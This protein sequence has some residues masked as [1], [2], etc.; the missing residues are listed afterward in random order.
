MS[1]A[2]TPREYQRTAVEKLIK[3]LSDEGCALLWA[4]MGTGKTTMALLTIKG[5]AKGPVLVVAPAKVATLSWP[6]EMKG[7]FPE[8]SF[9]LLTGKSA[10]ARL[11]VLRKKP[12]VMI[13]NYELLQWLAAQEIE[14]DGIIFDEVDRLKKVGG[15]WRNAVRTLKS[16]WRIGMT[17]TPSTEGYI[18]L[19]GQTDAV[20]PHRWGSFTRWKDRFFYTVRLFGGLY[21]P[22]KYVPVTHAMPILHELV[23]AIT[24]KVDPK[25]ADPGPFELKDHDITFPDDIRKVYARIKSGA[26]TGFGK[27][28][29]LAYSNAFTRCQQAASG[30][31]YD[32][33]KKPTWLHGLKYAELARL[34]Q[35]IPS[36]VLVAFQFEAEA[37]LLAKLFPGCGIIDGRK[38][39]S[40]I[41]AWNAG[42]L[43][44]MCIQ[45][46]SAGYG[47]NLQ[48]GTCRD[49]VFLSLPTSGRKYKQAIARIH[50][51]GNAGTVIV[52]RILIKGTTDTAT[53]ARI[54]EKIQGEQ[55]M[56]QSFRDSEV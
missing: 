23:N 10:N 52:H 48:K 16:R 24:V 47:L 30:F 42:K 49:I 28:D 25:Y 20:H 35:E 7:F 5:Y 41:D 14:F 18:D 17:G 15:A 11:A 12:Q 19:W 26:F 40:P 37:D 13:A 31:L 54:E 33:D 43:K 27:T 22:V 39:P 44:V 8:L 2:F 55:A 32:E 29:K 50:R 3:T 34:V 21:G 53:V 4:N 36:Q 38:R 6:S 9:G 51:Y 1:S 56:I 46:S 45:P